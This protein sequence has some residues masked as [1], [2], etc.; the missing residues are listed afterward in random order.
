MSQL[1][2]L[3]LVR[4]DGSQTDAPLKRGA[5]TAGDPFADVRD[6]AYAGADGVSA[7]VVSG[8]GGWSSEAYPF[9]EMLVVHKGRVS[10]R[11]NGEALEARPGESVVIEQG[12]AC[13]IDAADGSLW[14]FCALSGSAPS[15]QPALTWIDKRVALAPSAAPEASILIGPTPQCR[16][17]NAYEDSN[18]SLRIGV[19]DSTPY[20][21]GGRPH[22]VHE[23]MHLIEGQVT[24]TDAAG[25][26]LT[27]N[28][29]D[30]VFVPQ[31]ASCAWE[32]TV[33]VRKY[34]VVV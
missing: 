21:R 23:L 3:L 5:L 1:K 19:W 31:G 17:H 29:G 2:T 30:T 8:G 26:A 11:V 13:R 6:I 10:L 22:K 28:T 25:T 33:Y 14:A 27:V 9:T 12:V 32:S 18:S 24:L 20:A 16:S 4:A 15:T 34:Y 7:G